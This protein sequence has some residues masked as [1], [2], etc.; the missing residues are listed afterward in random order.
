MDK[1]IGQ[2]AVMTMQ[3]VGAALSPAMG[4]WMAQI[5]CVGAGVHRALGV[6]FG[7]VEEGL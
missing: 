5:G 7:I 6:L 2:G 3:G 1:N 4:G